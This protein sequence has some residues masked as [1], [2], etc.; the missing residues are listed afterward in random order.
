MDRQNW[1]AAVRKGEK[2]ELASARAEEKPDDQLGRKEKG[3]GVGPVRE[4]G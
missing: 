2:V 3:E 4:Q 1:A